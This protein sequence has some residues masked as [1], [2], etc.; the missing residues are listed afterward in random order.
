MSMPITPEDPHK[1][2]TF[3][4]LRYT[5]SLH[6][7]CSGTLH[8]YDAL[9][10]EDLAST[11]LRDGE[12]EWLLRDLLYMK[13]NPSIRIVADL[14]GLDQGS[15][16][17][18]DLWVNW[19]PRVERPPMVRGIELTEASIHRLS[20]VY[21]WLNVSDEY[22]P[23]KDLGVQ[24]EHRLEGETRW[25]DWM[26]A[27]IELRDGRWRAEITPG[28]DC[29]VGIYQFRVLV[30][31]SDD[32]NSG[33]TEVDG[34]LEVLNNP[35]SRPEITLG[36]LAPT[37]ESTLQVSIIRSGTDKEGGALSLRFH[38]FKNGAPIT[39]LT[40]DRVPPERTSKGQNWSVEVRAFDGDDE[41]PPATAW[42]VIQNSPPVVKGEIP[43][44]TLDEDTEDTSIEMWRLFTDPDG[45]ALVWSVNQEP[46]HISVEIDPD[47][48]FV[49]LTPDIDWFGEETLTFTASD[50]EYSV[51][52]TVV[53]TVNPVN[54]IPRF[55]S[56]NGE[57]LTGDAVTINVLQDGTLVVVIGAEDREGDELVFS[58]DSDLVELN[59]STGELRYTPTNEDI[60][61]FQVV[62]T[63]A[64][65]VSP[66]DTREL[67]ITIIVKNVNDPPTTPRITSPTSTTVIEVNDTLTFEGIS[68]DPD[69]LHGQTLTYSWS[70]DVSGHLG[71]GRVLEVTFTEAGTHTITLTV[72]DGEHQVTSTIQIQVNAPEPPPP[73]EPP[74]EKKEDESPGFGAL[75]LA[76][77]MFVAISMMWR[78]R[79]GGGYRTCLEYDG[80]STLHL[81][82]NYNDDLKHATRD[83]SGP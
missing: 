52:A 68:E 25:V 75:A 53:V 40:G 11:P 73:P 38:W 65:V 12:N 7:T 59:A 78:R 83:L 60:G 55:V 66:G 70:S 76:M 43:E 41:G 15:M 64:D 72:S 54:D 14:D 17:L 48:G 3:H 45:D 74:K 28:K 37:T 79:R 22:D 21:A 35:P 36:P 49:T 29:D 24:L 57:P 46:E 47:T 58:I 77:A 5:A 71:D 16:T 61:S 6:G 19:T 67:T 9:T 44:P 51:E 8:I 39:D 50:G 23:P 34:T 18:D 69:E 56:V 20:T 26:V 63:M 2:G 62:L 42:V 82:Y 10:W 1:T 80:L 4:T 32:M 81:S 31:D 33:W 13:E 30:W 27:N